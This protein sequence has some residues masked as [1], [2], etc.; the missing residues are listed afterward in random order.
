VE[1]TP[2]NCRVSQNFHL[3]FFFFF[4]KERKRQAK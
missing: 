2:S 4:K 1:E 3:N